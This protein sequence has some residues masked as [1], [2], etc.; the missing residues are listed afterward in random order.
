MEFVN[1][2]PVLIFTVTEDLGFKI[3]HLS[4]IPKKI[5]LY[6]MHF[7]LGGCTVHIDPRDHFVAYLFHKASDQYYYFDALQPQTQAAVFAP[8]PDNTLREGVLSLLVYFR[9]DDQLS[10]ENENE[11]EDEFVFQEPQPRKDDLPSEYS[12]RNLRPRST[13]DRNKSCHE[14]VAIS[15]D[16]L[17]EALILAGE[18]VE[19]ENQLGEN[20]GDQMQLG[21]NVG[22][23]MD[24]NS[25][26]D[27]DDYIEKLNHFQRCKVKTTELIPY[28]MHDRNVTITKSKKY[29]TE[30][31]KY[32]KSKKEIPSTSGNITLAVDADTGRAVIWDGNHRL[33]AIDNMKQGTYP[34]FVKVIFKSM[35]LRSEVEFK[36]TLFL[37]Q[38]WPEVWPTFMCGCM[39]GFTTSE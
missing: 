29:L 31:Q 21:E 33:T 18:N 22:N 4:E 36:G 12:P 14:Y 1:S 10:K 34:E 17:F 9:V 3:R 11:Y 27:D 25:E 20:V 23:Q 8:I 39:L 15:D 30:L 28:R 37:V 13:R 32:I 24:D 19:D 7:E 6:G 38:S 5:V 35:N 2:P 26:D 16:A